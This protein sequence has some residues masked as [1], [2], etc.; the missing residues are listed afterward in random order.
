MN[1]R[2][3]VLLFLSL[4][5]ANCK[6]SDHSSG[7]N[8]SHSPEAQSATDNKP[9][10]SSGTSKLASSSADVPNGDY[11]IVG[12]Q[13]GKCLDTNPN[14]RMQI[15]GCGPASKWNQRMTL[16]VN[17]TDNFFT[18][19]TRRLD[20]PEDAILC[21]DV[22]DHNDNPK[23]ILELK[24]C[25]DPSVN[26]QKWYISQLSHDWFQ[27]KNVKDGECMEVMPGP[28]GEVCVGDTCWVVQDICDPSKNN[29]QW[30]LK[31]VS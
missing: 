10:N 19:R 28:S 29:Q 17:S 5:F 2:A 3:F 8:V 9:A 11:Q 12:V 14:H 31:R 22:H 1:R 6:Q 7:S 20:K 4:L 23:Q 26:Q 24:E 15:F 21:V 27:I 13:S 16:T 18:I 25:D 30:R